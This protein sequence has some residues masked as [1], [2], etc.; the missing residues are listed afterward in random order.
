MFP[1]GSSHVILKVIQIKYFNCS[2]YQASRVFISKHSSFAFK[3]SWQF[4]SRKYSENF[5]NSFWAFGAFIF[6][7]SSQHLADNWCHA[8][9]QLAVSQLRMV[10]LEVRMLYS[11]RLD[12]LLLVLPLL[13]PLQQPQRPWPLLFSG[14]Q[15]FHSKQLQP[16]KAGM[17]SCD[18]MTSWCWGWESGLQLAS[19]QRL[20]DS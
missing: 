7:T 8:R 2:F 20:E 10:Q 18:R 13:P 9:E 15:Q 5:T 12:H 4:V 1:R 19:T 16:S 3:R 14:L 6:Q 11:V 17:T